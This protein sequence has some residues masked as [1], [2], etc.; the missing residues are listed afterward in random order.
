MKRGIARQRAAKAPPARQL[1]AATKRLTR[2]ERRAFPSHGEVVGSIPT[3]PTN[4][5]KELAELDSYTARVSPMKS[6]SKP[7]QRPSTQSRPDLQMR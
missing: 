6:V 3:A 1:S 4:I 5:I 7:S 2:H